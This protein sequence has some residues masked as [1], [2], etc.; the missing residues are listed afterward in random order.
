[1]IESFI[2]YLLFASILILLGYVAK[3]REYECTRH[4][5]QAPFISWEI[6]SIFF[7]FSFIS[8]V[9]WNVGVDYKNYLANYLSYQE[10]GLLIYEHEIGFTFLTKLIA[11]IGFHYSVYFA[12]LAFLQIS[13]IYVTFK[14]ERYLY[15]YL[16]AVII[17]GFHY[18]SWMN[19]IRQMI[20]ATIFVYSI[21]YIV[22]RRLILY[23][24]F[25]VIAF[26]FHKSILLLL[27][28]YLIPKITCFN[29]RFFT[30]ILVVLSIVIGS[31]D[32]LNTISQYM[33]GLL[34]FINYD[35]YAENISVLADEVHQRNIGPRALVIIFTYLVTLFYH[36]RLVSYFEGTNYNYYFG[37]STVGLLLSNLLVNAHHIFLRPVTYL[38]IFSLITT[39]YLLVYIKEQSKHVFIFVLIFLLSVLYLPISLL[40]D[41]G[42]DNSDY[43]NYRLYWYANSL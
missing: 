13:V 19:G 15:V 42:K 14:N 8:G 22:E 37:I 41:Y 12:I 10:T 43:S 38:T 30:L 11:D 7:I 34:N 28:L 39:S 9:R 24:F 16:G 36:N 27:P 26:L 1:M 17:G 29:N 20:A 33:I 2:I 6:L 18:L 40:S 23:V 5:R 4:G 35:F 21:R 25:I 3:L 31:F 32:F